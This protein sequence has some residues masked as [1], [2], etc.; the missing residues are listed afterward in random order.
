MLQT[1]AEGLALEEGKQINRSLSALSNVVQ[2]LT[3]AA[4]SHVLTNNACKCCHCL[5]DV[6]ALER[7]HWQQRKYACSWQDG[8][9]AIS[10]LEADQAGDPGEARDLCCTCNVV[11]RACAHPAVVHV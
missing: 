4:F 11:F 9:C 3:G 6:P 5:F 2:T 8:A 1:A 7:A 10:G